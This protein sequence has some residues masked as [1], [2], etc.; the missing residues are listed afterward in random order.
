MHAASG[1]SVNMRFALPPEP[2]RQFVTAYY[3]TDAVC[4]PREPWLEDYLHPE[5]ANLRFLLHTEAYSLIGPGEFARCPDFVVTGAT[6]RAARFRMRSGRSWGIGLMPAGWAALFAAQAGDY[7][8]RIV[9]GMTDPTFAR[10]VPL[11]RALAAGDGDYATELA[12]I[13]EHMAALFAD[14]QPVDPAIAALSE[15]LLD[16]G[17]VTVADLAERLDM[18]VRSLE[19]MSRRAF[20]FPPKLL[21]RR[22]R[23]LRCLA[24]FML[25][26]SLNWLGALDSGYHDQPHFVRDFRR[27]MRMSPSAYAK[28]DKPF[29]VAAA[30]ARM[31]IAGVA[32]QG[33]HRPP[34]TGQA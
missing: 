13:E 15:A 4:S 9:D 21:L 3:C 16:P 27:F 29:L 19:R 5:W 2:L 11:A 20:G 23:F 31:A 25:D 17:L 6:S 14:I 26:P 18:N 7:A 1:N 33:L 12:L 24:R 22:Q 8:D 10:M 32:L 34:G 28:L 30:R